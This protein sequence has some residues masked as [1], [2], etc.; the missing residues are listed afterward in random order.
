[1]Y[2]C[3]ICGRIPHAP[4]CPNAPDPV[5]VLT[6][7]LCGEG[8]FDGDEYLDS[9]KGPVC[10]SCLEDMTMRELLETAGE[11]LSTAQGGY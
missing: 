8:I 11:T 9:E 1:M 6:C 3:E 5:P 2:S 10:M 7:E 4:G